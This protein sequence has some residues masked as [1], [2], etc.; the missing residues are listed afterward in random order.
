MRHPAR[1]LAVRAARGWLVP[2]GC[3][4]SGLGFEPKGRS[5]P[6]LA[7]R[8]TNPPRRIPQWAGLVRLANEAEPSVGDGGRGQRLA[9]TAETTLAGLVPDPVQGEG[10]ATSSSALAARMG[11]RT[12]SCTRLAASWLITPSTPG[13]GRL[14]PGDSFPNNRRCAAIDTMAAHLEIRQLLGMT[15][16]ASGNGE[17]R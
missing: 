3:L 8:S 12:P 17:S 5:I 1:S 13:S 16:H 14:P 9:E 15:G 6:D 10:K 7:P 11:G 2:C 4:R